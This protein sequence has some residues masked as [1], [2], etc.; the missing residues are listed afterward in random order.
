MK[1]GVLMTSDLIEKS[2]KGNNDATLLMIEKFNPLLKKYAYKLYY[3]DA[4]NDL[5]VDFIELI[6]NIRLDHIRNK[7]EGSIVSYICKSI[8]SSFSRKLKTVIKLRKF[9][10][11]SDLGENEL[12]Y[13]DVLSAKCDEYFENGLPGI[14]LV[15]TQTEMSVIEMIYYS[16][17]TV[18]ETASVY[19]ISRQAVN[20][21]K[22]RALKKLEAIFSDKLERVQRT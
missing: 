20:Q 14:S 11:L 17:Y 8:H 5:L 16:G 9:T 7:D 12:Y 1:G 10:L 22:K 21:A 19:G 3:E 2:Q 6:H 13:I 15:L 4:Y 18:T